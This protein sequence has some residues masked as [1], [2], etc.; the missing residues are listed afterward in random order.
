[1]QWNSKRDLRGVSASVGALIGPALGYVSY[2]GDNPQEHVTFG[3]RAGVFADLHLGW[4]TLGVDSS[5][6]FGMASG[7]GAE[8][9]ASAGLH[10]GVRFDV[11]RR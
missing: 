2:G 9:F 10:A 1:M 7:F 4:F 8:S 6:R 11:A 5:M 3:G